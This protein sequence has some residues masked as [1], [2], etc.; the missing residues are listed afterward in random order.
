MENVI[1]FFYFI[2]TSPNEGFSYILCEEN[3]GFQKMES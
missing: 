3:A 2:N 1:E